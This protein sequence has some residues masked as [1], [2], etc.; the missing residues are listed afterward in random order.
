MTPPP[1][2]VRNAIWLDRLWLLCS[3]VCPNVVAKM[4]EAA[5]HVNYKFSKPSKEM[6]KQKV[7]EFSSFI[8]SRIQ[9]ILTEHNSSV[10]I[11]LD[12]VS[13]TQ[14]ALY[15][16]SVTF[17]KSGETD[18]TDLPFYFQNVPGGQD[19]ESLQVYRRYYYNIN[20]L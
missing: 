9:K 15:F 12:I 4:P 2:S 17:T 7:S 5:C 11:Q 19:A 16:A 6:L 3:G 14:R 8:D 10:S 13:D 20:F 18:M 1:N